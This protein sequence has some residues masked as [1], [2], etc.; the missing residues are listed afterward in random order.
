MGADHNSESFEMTKLKSDANVKNLE[1]I[2]KQMAQASDQ[3]LSSGI[4]GKE[5]EVRNQLDRMRQLKSDIETVEEKY[6]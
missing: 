6:K 2:L 1:S 4:E 3:I 5:T